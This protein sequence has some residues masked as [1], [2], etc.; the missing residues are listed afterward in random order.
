MQPHIESRPVVVEKQVLQ[1]SRVGESRQEAIENL[2]SQLTD[3]KSE[4]TK[5]VSRQD[6]TASTRRIVLLNNG[7][8]VFDP[9]SVER[10]SNSGDNPNQQIAPT[11]IREPIS[12]HLE[13][14]I[15]TRDNS[16]IF[17]QS[18]DSLYEKREADPVVRDFGGSINSSPPA[19]HLSFVHNSPLPSHPEQSNIGPGSPQ[20]PNQM[21]HT[22]YVLE[23]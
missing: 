14:K 7:R 9:D 23:L 11:I 5:L 4:A 18:N 6:S 15:L 1:N 3:L 2:K 22:A 16:G 12:K 21:R 8:R 13:P 17:R 10:M 20:P 19:P